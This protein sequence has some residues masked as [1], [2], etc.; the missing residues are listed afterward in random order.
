MQRRA[1]CFGITAIRV[2]RKVCLPIPMREIEVL[3]SSV[4]VSNRNSV[5]IYLLVAAALFALLQ[6][7][8]VLAPVLLSFLLTMLIS[9]ALNPVIN[10]LRTIAGGR[11]GATAVVIV[12]LLTVLS[13]AGWAFYLPLSGAVAKFSESL[14]T[15]WERLQKPLIKL[16]KKAEHSEEKLQQE[17]KT[18]I[19]KDAAASKDS[20]MVASKPEAMP[21]QPNAASPNSLRSGL[22]AMMR[23]VVG[24]VTAMAFNGAQV[25]VV[26]LT[27]FFGVVFMLLNPRPII[28]AIFSLVPEQH[29]DRAVIITQRIAQFAPAWAGSTLAG[30]LTIGVLV[31]LLM[32]PLLGLMDALVLGLIACLFES[33]PFLGPTLSTIPAL[34][35]AIGKGGMTPLWV[36]VAYIAIQ[37]L[38]N[39]V[40]LPMIMSRGMK[41]HAVAVI[42]SMLLCV[43]AFGVLGVLIAAP[44]VAIVS[45]VH[46][47]L[48]RKRFLPTVT[49]EDLDRLARKVLH[50]R[51]IAAD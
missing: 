9:L 51:N 28:A 7:F 20:E 21:P 1:V 39:N 46:E 42:F 41:I 47:E 23:G 48:Y 33:I 26:L 50:E 3:K 11:K 25:L 43:T 34:L 27:V 37:T 2:F 30:M 45:I 16:E 10:W 12:V 40:I 32:W 38:E 22:S 24:N 18:E 17:V 13:L 49:E 6:A 15:Y 19:A 31:F 44:M 5:P 8:S 4:L 29:H 36:L 14:P 35:L